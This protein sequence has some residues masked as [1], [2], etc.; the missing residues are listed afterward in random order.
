MSVHGFTNIGLHSDH[1]IAAFLRKHGAIDNCR[2]SG[3]SNQWHDASGK[4]V[5]VAFYGGEGG[6][7]T[8]YW[9]ADTLANEWIVT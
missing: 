5:L 4:V 6:F 2:K 7:V 8:A 9:V 1:D 3:N